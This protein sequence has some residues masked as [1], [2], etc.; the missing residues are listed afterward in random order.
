MVISGIQCEIPCGT[1]ENTK[2]MEPALKSTKS[3]SVWSRDSGLNLLK[4]VRCRLHRSDANKKHI[5][6]HV[7]SRQRHLRL[8]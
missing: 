8:R 2:E 7:S 4:I 1:Y 5:K 6:Q 3:S